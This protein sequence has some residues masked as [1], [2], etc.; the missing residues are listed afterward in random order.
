MVTDKIIVDFCV[1]M[2]KINVCGCSKKYQTKPLK[3]IHHV[4]N[5]T[6]RQKEMF[7]FFFN[8]PS[9]I[10]IFF[11][12]EF[13]NNYFT[14]ILFFSVFILLPNKHLLY[15]K[16]KWSYFIFTVNCSISIFVIAVGKL[17][18]G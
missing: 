8:F 11:S 18:K 1:E 3:K 9:Q 15:L 4:S 12:A 5:I 17:N 16:K 14:V 2:S 10:G 6:N 13:L 7:N